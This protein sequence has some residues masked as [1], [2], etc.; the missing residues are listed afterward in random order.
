MSEIRPGSDEALEAG[1]E[2]AFGRPRSSVLGELERSVGAP[3]ARVSL[4]GA[5]EGLPVRDEVG[6]PERVEGHSTYRVLGEL[7]RGGMGILYRGEDVDL[8]RDV[9]LK[10]L[11]EELARRPG[12]VQRFVEEAQ[13]AGQ[14]QHP[15]VVPVHELGLLPDGRPYFAMKL[16]QGRTFAEALA[17][18]GATGRVRWIDTFASVCRTVAYAH[19]RGVVHRD[20]KPA[21]VL[22]GKFG[23]VQVIDWGLAKVL[24]RSAG[25]AHT[26][27]A[28]ASQAGQVLGTP[29]YM[30]PEQAR[31]DNQRVDE[32]ADVFALGA[33]LCEILTGAPPYEG[34]SERTVVLAGH[35]ELDDARKRLSS[36]DAAPELV[37]L[38]LECLAPDPERR[39][40]T[41][42]VV[43][44]SVDAYLASLAERAR[45]AE[46]RAAEARVRSKAT[47]GVSAVVV[48]ALLGAGWMTFERRREREERSLATERSVA[49][50]LEDAQLARGRG[51]WS[52]AES[53]VRLAAGQLAG[54]ET[55]EELHAK[56][57]SVAESIASEASAARAALELASD[58]RAWLV[59]LE[60]LR[61]PEGDTVYP[62]DWAR[63]DES[64]AATFRARGL[65][66]D[67][68]APATLLERLRAR[69]V[70]AELAAAL[71][72]WSHA[73]RRAGN[74]EGAAR[75]MAH[76][77]ALDPQPERVTLR[78]ALARADL[79]TIADAAR[80]GI[81]AELPA[82]TLRL[83]ALALRDGEHADL[84]LQLLRAGRRRHPTDFTLAMQLARS[85]RR[86]TPPRY[87][88][89]LG[90]YQ[91][92]LSL[93]PDNVE[94]WHELAMT[95]HPLLGRGDEALATLRMLLERFPDD[96]HLRFHVGATLVGTGRP[97]EALDEL[98]RA[99]AA[100]EETAQLHS[101]LGVCLD[102][103]G[104][105]KESIAHYER[106]LEL[107]ERT[108]LAHYNF[109]IA[110]RGVGRLDEAFTH[111]QRAAE[112]D[113]SFALA[114][115]Q[116]AYTLYQRKDWA[117]LV[118]AA[119]RAVALDPKNFNHHQYLGR[120]LEGL[121]RFAESRASYERAIALAPESPF[122]RR[123]LL[124][125]LLTQRDDPAAALLHA[126]ELV[127]RDRTEWLL[128]GLAA[129]G[130]G[131]LAE[132]RRVF[133]VERAPQERDV[134]RLFLALCSAREGDLPGAATQLEA[135]DLAQFDS[136]AWLVAPH[137]A[138]ARGL[139]AR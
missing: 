83:V 112:L 132:A 86:T 61:Q 95:L 43:A 6:V 136:L 59:Q 98:E 106:A 2:F 72:E 115:T 64:F 89:A 96:G 22:L 78:E 94:A 67:E 55:S 135:L 18:T 105:S 24:G 76:A 40:R 46:L 119:E 15:G 118:P 102:Q 29:A 4:L 37:E 128:H 25:T 120:G 32:R 114:A 100:G 8:G 51:E 139:L 48:V 52:E 17:E 33:V 110:L 19:S 73:R 62:R 81:E 38:C 50:A 108:M 129:F 79:A 68:L 92:A 20:L 111:F 124:L 121:G 56:V 109:G 45:K 88:E 23:E 3:L 93:R 130:A 138:E 36:C 74:E 10:V 12:V 85:L 44:A 53:K 107:D 104:R 77:N 54:Q 122:P 11:R 101:N 14:L 42:G 117:A 137:V 16:V 84:S 113:P 35:A 57:R 103:L 127:S 116:V 58:T 87:T 69:G 28:R 134:C 63:L 39:P 126:R 5:S 133:S 60:S 13:V 91:A 34:E 82:S 123:A 70:D 75:L 97:A 9:A 71:D 66:V 30:P 21:N 26:G 131:E 90:L 7:A 1:L 47:L 49:R 27:E 65:D 80:R 99:R 31:G 41:A 125:Q